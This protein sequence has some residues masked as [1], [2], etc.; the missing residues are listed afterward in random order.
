MP[1]AARAPR[2]SFGICISWPCLPFTPK[3]CLGSRLWKRGGAG[4]RWRRKRSRCSPG[5]RFGSAGSRLGEGWAGLG[6]PRARGMA[7]SPVGSQPPVGPRHCGEDALG[8]RLPA[9]AELLPSSPGLKTSRNSSRLRFRWLP[10]FSGPASLPFPRRILLV[11]GEQTRPRLP[12]ALLAVHLAHPGAVHRVFFLPGW[13]KTAGV[14]VAGLAA[15]SI[16]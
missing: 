2:R 5:L 6:V 11:L 13:E 3:S 12:A 16:A 8:A 15:G 1:A 9:P 7:H 14:G 10:D 4:C